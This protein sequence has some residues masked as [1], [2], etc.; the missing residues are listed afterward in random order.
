M[1]FDYFKVLFQNY[2][3]LILHITQYVAVKGMAV[4]VSLT[5]ASVTCNTSK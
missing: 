4:A 2:Y 5:V 1:L 3:L